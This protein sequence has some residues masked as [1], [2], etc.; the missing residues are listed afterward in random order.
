M[1]SIEKL[2]SP[3]YYGDWH[4][5]PLKWKVVGP[6]PEVQKFST[7]RDSMTYK[8]LRTK[9]KTQPEAINA[10]ILA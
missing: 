2:P 10:Y 9:V 5:K 3:E 6:G 7:K 1:I 8:R 4:D